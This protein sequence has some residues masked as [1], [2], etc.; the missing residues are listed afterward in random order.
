MYICVECGQVFEEPDVFYEHHPYG[1]GYAE[2]RWRVCPRCGEA[3][4]VKAKMCDCCGEYV[5]EL[6]DGLCDACYE[7]EEG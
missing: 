3:G 4:F 1:M 5:A 7:E 2:E 6:T